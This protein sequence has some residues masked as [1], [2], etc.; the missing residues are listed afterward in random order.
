MAAEFLTYFISQ[1][2]RFRIKDGA[3]WKTHQ[4]AINSWKEAKNLLIVWGNPAS[5]GGSISTSE[6]KTL[7][8]VCK[9]ALSYF[10]CIECKRK[11][12]ALEA[13][14]YVRC[15]CDSIRWKLE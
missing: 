2:E 10:D 1:G 15:Q 11:V 13:P 12:W 4:D 6:A 7:V 9:K 14:D 3:K 5:H 8:D